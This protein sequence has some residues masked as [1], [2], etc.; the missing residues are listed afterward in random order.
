LSIQR[1]EEL[2]G[3]SVAGI[4]AYQEPKNIDMLQERIRYLAGSSKLPSVPEF[5]SGSW[6][7][8]NCLLTADEEEYGYL[9]SFMNGLKAINFYM[10]VERDRWTGCPI[11]V[12]GRI[13]ENF[14]QMFKNMLQMLKDEKIY[15]YQRKPKILILKN[16]DMGRFKA[17]YSV[18][19]LNILS[20]N[21]FITGPDLPFELF[22]PDTALGLYMDQDDGH[23]AREEWI[24]QITKALNEQHYDFNY[25]DQY[26]K[27]E[28]WQE[29]DVIFASTY[30]FMDEDMQE[31]LL[32]FAQGSGK[33]L[34][35]GPCVP[36]LDRNFKQC[37]I[38]KDAI[39][40]GNDAEVQNE[41]AVCSIT[42]LPDPS[43]FSFD[44]LNMENEYIYEA[45]NVEISL[46]YHSSGSNHLLFIANHSSQM[47]TVRFY[48]Q[49]KR[50]LRSIWRGIGMNTNNMLIA[51]LL[52]YTVS[53][54]KVEMEE[55]A[56]DKQ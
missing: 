21:C 19:D 10:L 43:Q 12:D 6:F 56:D 46:H 40:Q 25:S 42:V 29:Y 44:Y 4:D 39:E 37:T 15:E 50:N 8:R 38:L 17:L 5:G 49:H 55:E 45:D 41:K 7:D 13:R 47:K 32:Q 30:D 34:F 1:D 11:T 33:K 3:L 14:Y 16:Y 48:Y 54:W 28:K 22:V 35:I 36:Y 31:N 52:P 23:Y 20:S 53:I 18:M 26:L 2:D 9:Y 51:E 24:L 27:K